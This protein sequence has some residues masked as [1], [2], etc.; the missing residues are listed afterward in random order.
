MLSRYH[1][2][3]KCFNLHKKGLQE[4]SLKHLSP[5]F[6]RQDFSTQ[7]MT[8]IPH[9]Q[10][11]SSTRFSHVDATANKRRFSSTLRKFIKKKVT[12]NIAIKR[13]IKLVY[14][15]RIKSSTA[16]PKTHLRTHGFLK[17]DDKQQRFS[18]DGAI[19][20]DPPVLGKAHQI[21]F[22]NSLCN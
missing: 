17:E 11:S 1:L 18:E 16:T 12:G 20:R 7:E 15:F 8:E 4:V 14:R 21:K 19:F 5:S 9:T 2:V 10:S 22:E 13:C 3:P 6:Y